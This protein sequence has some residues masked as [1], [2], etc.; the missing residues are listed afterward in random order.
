MNLQENSDAVKL[1]KEI[2]QKLS[3]LE[4]MISKNTTAKYTYSGNTQQHTPPRKRNV[5]KNTDRNN[6]K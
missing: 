1:I 3:A 4:R 2:K 6:K 5:Y